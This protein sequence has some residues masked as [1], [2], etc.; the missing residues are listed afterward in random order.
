MIKPE[1]AVLKLKTISW[2]NHLKGNTALFSITSAHQREVTLFQLRQK[3]LESINCIC[4][5][6]KTSEVS[7]L[8]HPC[9]SLKH[10]KDFNFSTG[11]NPEA[12]YKFYKRKT[13]LIP[14]ALILPQWSPED[15]ELQGDESNGPEMRVE[16]SH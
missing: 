9:R 2:D 16:T 5:Y 12:L 14:T 4:T 3:T 8:L 13:C 1:L 11:Q 6:N 10:N 15:H 7:N